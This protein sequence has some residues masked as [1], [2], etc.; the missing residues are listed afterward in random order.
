MNDIYGHTSKRLLGSYDHS[1]LSWRTSEDILDLGFEKSLATLPQ[2]GMTQDGDLY[3]LV[4]LE[5]PIEEKDYLS[6][7]TPIAHD[8]HEPSPATYKRHSPG[9]AAIILMNIPTPT[10][11]DAHWSET[12]AERNGI[13]GNHN[14]SLTSWSR[15]IL[16]TPTTAASGR[17]S[18]FAG[19]SAPNP[20]ELA[21]LMLQT[22]SQFIPSQYRLHWIKIN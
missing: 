7:P 9:I 2:S 4:T 6:L 22:S 19:N 12:T 15:R 3:E 14:L 17:S 13:K 18:A 8:G 11:S 5:R 21:T 16:G 1:T 20:E 10:A